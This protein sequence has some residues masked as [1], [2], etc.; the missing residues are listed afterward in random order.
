[1]TRP[2]PTGIRAGDYVIFTFG[3]RQPRTAKALSG[4]TRNT[5]G[6]GSHYLL[7][8]RRGWERVQI[9]CPAGYVKPLPP[10]E[11]EAGAA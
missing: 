1:M 6:R 2:Q 8:I 9:R 10:V 7:E 4:R 5:E 3:D 11:E